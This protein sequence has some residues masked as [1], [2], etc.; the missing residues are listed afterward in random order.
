MSNTHHDDNSHSAEGQTWLVLANAEQ[1]H[2]LWPVSRPVPE[3]WLE[4]GPEGSRED[5]LAWIDQH[6]TD[7]RPASL[8]AA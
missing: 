5:C 7:M 4:V 3:G 1:Q 2:A 6:W 8:R